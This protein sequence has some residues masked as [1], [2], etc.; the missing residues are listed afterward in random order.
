MKPQK[1][2]KVPAKTQQT[3]QEGKEELPIQALPL[4][5]PFNSTMDQQGQGT[6]LANE[7]LEDL[8]IPG[9]QSPNGSDF[10][11]FEMGDEYFD[12]HDG[13]SGPPLKGKF[14]PGM[15][16]FDAAT[17]EER[18]KRNQR[19][20]VSVIQKMKTASQAVETS[21]MVGDLTLAWARMRDVYDPPS[22]DDETPVRG[23]FDPHA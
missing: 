17:E 7:E 16:I 11:T 4:T 2:R 10:D 12:R 19:K 6:L 13:P 21:E 15:G 18:R 3:K 1:R 22:C 8:P 5:T 9:L 20:D 14:W 23:S